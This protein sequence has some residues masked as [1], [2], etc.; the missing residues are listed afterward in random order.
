MKNL[1][2]KE[3]PHIGMVYKGKE[4]G[5]IIVTYLKAGIIGSDLF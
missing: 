2:D 1:A 3:W 5:T 4:D